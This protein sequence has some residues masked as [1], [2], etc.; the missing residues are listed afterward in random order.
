MGQP[1]V[2]G[3]ALSNSALNKQLNR[4]GAIAVSQVPIIVALG[5]HN[6]IISFELSPQ[7]DGSHLV[8]YGLA[9]HSGQDDIGHPSYLAVAFTLC[10]SEPINYF[11]LCTVSLSYIQGH[12]IIF[13]NQ[14]GLLWNLTHH[15]TLGFRLFHA[16]CMINFG[17]FK[18][19]A[20]MS[21]DFDASVDILSSQFLCITL[22]QPSYFCW[23][24]SQ[25]TYLSFPG[26]LSLPF[27]AHPFTIST[28][29]DPNPSPSGNKLVFFT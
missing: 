16:F 9:S 28:T 2:I 8:C 14:N 25:S 17:Y 10:M 24:T 23:V 6:N 13:I 3:I 20:S 12:T 4:A 29:Y 26:L 22:H 21:K 27:E 11:S 1:T 7:N 15:D 19:T 18:P 5:T